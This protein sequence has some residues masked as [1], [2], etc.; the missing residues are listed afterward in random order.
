MLWQSVPS[1]VIGKHQRLRS[2]VDKEWAKQQSK[3]IIG[4]CIARSKWELLLL[5]RERTLRSKYITF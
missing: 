3:C 5:R 2:E 1:V 4:N